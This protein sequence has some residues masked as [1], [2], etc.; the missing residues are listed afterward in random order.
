MHALL[1]RVTTEHKRVA[2]S[3]TMRTLFLTTDSFGGH[4]G[5]AKYNRDLLL[6]LSS[7]PSVGEIVVLPRRVDGS[8][9]HLPAKL[10]FVTDGVGSK[11]KFLTTVARWVGRPGR[12]DLVVCAHINLI[13]PALVAAWRYHARLILCIY[14]IDAWTRHSRTAEWACRAIYG[15]VSISQV[16]ADR[17]RSWA[18]VKGKK[19]W[20]LPN[21][22]EL[23]RFSPGPRNPTLVARYGLEGKTVIATLARLDSSERMKGVD[24]VLEILPHL[25]RTHPGLVYLIMGDGSDKERLEGRARALGLA[26]HVA[27]AG[28]I[29]EAEKTDHYRLA[30]AFVMP[31]RGEGFGFVFLEALACG[32]PVVAS[33]IDGGREAVRDGLLGSLV[34]PRN[35]DDIVRGIEEA[36]GKGVGLVPPGL[37]YFSF[38]NFASR[39]RR[40]VGDLACP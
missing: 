2:E 27:F 3:P 14:G 29:L 16:T 22:V 38:E 19:E 9:E 34:D 7:D 23:D 35:P 1:G 33:S 8:I 26:G 10:T 28:R 11:A 21:A 25:L 18:P 17:F 37:S 4:G 6:A 15:F 13:Q 30:D 36:L 39:A 12:F 31:S 20:I 40:F 24:E 32:V 5:L